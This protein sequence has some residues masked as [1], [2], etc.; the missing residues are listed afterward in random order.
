MY[1]AFMS[2]YNMERITIINFEEDLSSYFKELNVAWLKKYFYVEP[3]DEEMLGRPKENIIDKGGHIFFAKAGSAIAGTVA[4]IKVAGDEFELGKMAVDEQFQGK[5]I[6]HLLIDHCIKQAKTLGAKKIILYS[7]TILKPAIHLYEKFG[8][9]E[10]P[11]VNSEYK[12]SN[13]KMEKLLV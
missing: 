5:K 8:F 6:G 13:I 12:R 4:L 1:P 9:T 10:L 2:N 3:V 11:I 7:N